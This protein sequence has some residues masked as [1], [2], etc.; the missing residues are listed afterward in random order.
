MRSTPRV[1]LTT[2]RTLGAGS[3]IGQGTL[4]AYREVAELEGEPHVV[5]RDLA[6]DT[7]QEAVVSRRAIIAIG[8]I[9]D[10]HVA[11]VQS[12]ARFE[13][14][15]REWLDPRFRD[16]LTMQRPHEAL[17]MHAIDAMVRTLNAIESAPVTGA[18]LELVAMTGDAIDNTQRNEL[19]NFLALFDGGTV[20]PD[21]GAPGYEGVQAAD[22]PDDLCWKPDGAA[23]G[24]VFRRD[25][26]FP[27][28]PGLLDR[29]VQ[30]F[31]ATGLRRPWLG[32]HGNHEEVCQGMGIVTPALAKAM[33]GS[34]KPVGL[35]PGL[36]PDT[37]VDTFIERPEFFMSGPSVDVSPDAKRRPISRAEFVESLYASG[38]HGFTDQNRQEGTAYYV[39]D[40]PAV[41]FITLDT[42]CAAG[43]TDGAIDAPQ[44]HWLERRLEE[45]HASFRS[46]DGS[47]VQTRHRDRLV[48]VLS[49]HGFDSLAN[50]RCEQRNEQ[51]LELLLRFQNVVLW[52]NGHI[53]A[54]RITPRVAPQGGHGF[55]E[56]TTSSLVDW[57][58]QARLVE[59]FEAGEGLLGIAC[60]MVDHEGT[61]RGHDGEPPD[62]AGL[63]RELAGNVPSNGFD[64]WRPGTPTDRNAILLMPSPF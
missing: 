25:L 4:A 43:D 44:L 20:E 27:E 42:V 40:T 26:G 51:L 18:P 16:L 38:P 57:P 49:H 39:H 31:Q 54:N 30:S 36:N 48:V 55:W 62:L 29:A 10:L 24:D 1:A 63:H 12:P 3:V 14:I 60:T 5:R 28:V 13:Y 17:T 52:L 34:R 61:T 35:P 7:S 2:Q 56:V 37:A 50:P 59:L 23:D 22:W 21:S 6:G 58:C 46:R 15:N 64:S 9:T 53:H 32:C 19:V 11:D 47:T 41:R 33:T 45:A 8:H